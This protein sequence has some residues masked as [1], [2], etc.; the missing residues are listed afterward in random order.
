MNFDVIK[1]EITYKAV[2]SSG[3]GGQ[4]VNKVSTKIMIIFAMRKSQGL[5]E[6][7]KNLLADKL[8]NKIST[9]GEIV[10]SS[11]ESRSQLKNKEAAVNKLY[12]MLQLA[13][14]VKQKRVATKIPKGVIK[15]RIEDKKLLSFKKNMR[16][17]INL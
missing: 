1:R 7:E 16:K 3:A 4:H 12:N 10:I 9:E 13:L 11:S 17:N 6:L 5:S 15:K 2:R 8:S 14:K